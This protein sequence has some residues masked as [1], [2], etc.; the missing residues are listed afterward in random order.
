MGTYPTSGSAMP[1]AMP[2][3]TPYLPAPIAI[4][5]HHA[6]AFFLVSYPVVPQCFQP[7]L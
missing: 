4:C 2:A 6:A 7:Q 3:G 5:L 1:G